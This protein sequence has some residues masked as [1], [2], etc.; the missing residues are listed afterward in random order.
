MSI[1][2]LN[3]EGT[4]W[5]IDYYPQGRKGQRTMKTFI[6]NEADARAYEMDLRRTHAR[7]MPI[8]P[9]VIDAV[10]DWLDWYKVNKAAS[11]YED[12][13]KTLKHLRPYFGHLKFSHITPALIEQYKAKR[14][15]SKILVG[16]KKKKEGE[17]TVKKRTVNKELSYLSSLLKFAAKHNYCH[18]LPFQIEKFDKVRPPKPVIPHPEEIQA[19]LNNMEPEYLLPALLMYDTGLRR[20]EAMHVKAEDVFIKQGFF[21][22]I[23]KGDKERLVPITTDRLK[24][25]FKASCENVRKGYLSKN[26]KTGKPWYSIR[27]ALARAAEKAG[28]SHRVYHHLLRHSFGTHGLAA[29][30]SMRALQGIMGHE[31]IT[32]T[33]IYAHLLG[34][35]LGSEG[36]KFGHYIGMQKKLQPTEKKKK[37]ETKK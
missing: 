1:R 3:K 22:V 26:P 20:S 8:S 11:T 29:G 7:A 32:T 37:T 24:K 16:G 9:K 2:P 30:I 14:L 33:E 34:D 4:K 27:K 25:A 6:G 28:I 36:A 21:R 15:S 19:L 23:G 5:V 31:D 18:P 35:F 13:K 17:T 12:V 10:A